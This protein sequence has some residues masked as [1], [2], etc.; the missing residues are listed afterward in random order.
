MSLPVP[1]ALSL[2]TSAIQQARQRSAAG[3]IP[4]D[5]SEPED[6]SEC[7][8]APHPADTPS[9][10]E[11]RPTPRALEESTG[12][13]GDLRAGPQPCSFLSQGQVGFLAAGLRAL[14]CVRWLAAPMHPKTCMTCFSSVA[15][16]YFHRVSMATSGSAGVHYRG[17][18]PPTTGMSR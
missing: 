7:F 9:D 6:S 8:L 3:R 11:E 10:G 2:I 14:A 17:W 12:A 16:P 5:S 13:A 4:A 1:S 15:C 18:V